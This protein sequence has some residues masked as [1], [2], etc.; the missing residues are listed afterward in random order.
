MWPIL[1]VSIIAV[2]VVLERAFWWLGRW[3]RRDPKR[4]EKVFTA[5]E[6]GDVARLRACRAVHA[7]R[8]CA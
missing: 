3:M 8:F 1:I 7:I 6:I 4:I 5:I 2:T